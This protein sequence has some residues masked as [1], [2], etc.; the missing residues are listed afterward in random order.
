[1]TLQLLLMLAK[2][3]RMKLE[4]CTRNACGQHRA[5]Q[6]GRPSTELLDRHQK[7]HKQPDING[8][9][10]GNLHAYYEAPERISLK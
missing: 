4:R 10:H 5:L 2:L 7:T 8:M 9:G 3:V 1:M 6:L